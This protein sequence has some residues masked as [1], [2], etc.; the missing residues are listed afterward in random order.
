MKT[1]P[2]NNIPQKRY[3]VIYARYS[4]GPNQTEQS[5]EGQIHDCLSY[6]KSHNITIIETYDYHHR[7]LR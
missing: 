5:I 4:N 1:K 2:T 7:N 6:A 3:G